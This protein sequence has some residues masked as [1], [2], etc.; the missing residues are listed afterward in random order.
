LLRLIRVINLVRPR[1]SG[2]ELNAAR[3]IPR[4][5]FIAAGTIT[6]AIL[7]DP[8]T[9]LRN[10]NVGKTITKTTVFTLS[11]TPTAPELGGGTANIAFLQGA[12]TRPN[13]GPNASAELIIIIVNVFSY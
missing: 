8:N 4:E 2:Q 1:F 12:P 5:P 10:A 11:T 3:L 13:E 6:Q 9:V 7:T